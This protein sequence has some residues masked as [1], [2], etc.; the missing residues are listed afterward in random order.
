MFN[1]HLARES[2]EELA[3]ESRS[4][5]VRNHDRK[6]LTG[7]SLKGGTPFTRSSDRMQHR[8]LKELRKIATSDTTMPPSPAGIHRRRNNHPGCS[9]Q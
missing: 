3:T 5:V 4:H 7:S 2:G 9:Q 1:R 8:L 6:K